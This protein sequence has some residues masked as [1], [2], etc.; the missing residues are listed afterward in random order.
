MEGKKYWLRLP[1]HGFIRIPKLNLKMTSCPKMGGGR[2][3][4][5][6]RREGEEGEGGKEGEESRKKRRKE[7]RIGRR[8]YPPYCVPDS[9]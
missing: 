1:T 9:S 3:K 8:T 7:I 2:R 5:E 6:K 4:R